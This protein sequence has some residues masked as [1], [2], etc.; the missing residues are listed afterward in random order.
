M[1]DGSLMME[2]RACGREDSFRTFKVREMLF[3]WRHPAEYGE[4][5]HCAS[6]QITVIPPNLGEYYPSDYYSLQAP[7]LRAKR[8]GLFRKA[9]AAW[10][11]SGPGGGAAASG[12]RRKYP[13]FHWCREAGCGLG[14]RILDV[15]CGSG[16]LLRRMQRYGFSDLT[17]VDPYTSIEADEPGFRVMRA[18]LT[19]LGGGY[20]LIM[21]HH[22]LEHLAD[23]KGSLGELRGRLAPG[24]RLLVR[25]PVAASET[26]R[27]YGPDW[28]N[29][30]PPRHLLVPSRRGMELL[31]ERS[32]FRVVRTEFDGIETGYL[33]SENYRRDVPYTGRPPDDPAKKKHYRRLAEAANRRGEGDQGVFWLEAK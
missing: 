12:M 21:M 25:I 26:A 27:L 33:Y 6:L 5:P 17:G 9:W 29:L 23:P 22:V 18:E 7:P 13:F 32:G 2:C 19:A 3:G 10:L 31:A 16:G 20:D 8:P 30:D 11:L 15:G 4:C 28:F 24:G 1:S 14:A